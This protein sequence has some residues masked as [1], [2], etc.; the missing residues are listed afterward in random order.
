MHLKKA[1]FASVCLISLPSKI[2]SSDY[3]SPKLTNLKYKQKYFISNGRLSTTI[4]FLRE[5]MIFFY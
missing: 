4:N 2:K 3:L 1:A 5:Q